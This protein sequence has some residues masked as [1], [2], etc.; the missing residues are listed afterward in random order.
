MFKKKKSK[1]CYLCAHSG[2]NTRDH[3]PPRGIFPKR[4]SG[5]LITVPAHSICNGKFAQDDRLFRDLVIYVSERSPSARKAWT[6]QVEPSFKKDKRARIELQ[7]RLTK[8]W[9]TDMAT[10]LPVLH[11][12]MQID[13]AVIQRQVDRWTRGLF[14]HRFKEPMPPDLTIEV[15]KLNPPELSMIDLRNLMAE[16]GRK[17]LWH[18]IEPGVFSYFYVTTPEDRL[19]GTVFYVFFDTE[20]FAAVMKGA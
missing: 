15:D 5:Q 4:P 20:V 2:A 8:T 3:V 17:P 11:D 13:V 1:L 7:K 16:H 12:A 10:G 18:H 9:V 19:K 14:Y 6:L